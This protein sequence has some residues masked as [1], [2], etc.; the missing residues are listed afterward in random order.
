[1]MR[2]SSYGVLAVDPAR[3]CGLAMI[4][5]GGMW[6]HTLVFRHV[7]SQ[8][9]EVALLLAHLDGEMPWANADQWH[10]VA[11]QM[12][13][14]KHQQNAFV[15]A[16]V[17]GQIYQELGRMR[18]FASAQR[19]LAGTW[20]N[21][22]WRG[23]GFLQRDLAKAAAIDLVQRRYGVT[24][25]DNSAEAICIALWRQRELEREAKRL[26]LDLPR[27][28]RRKRRVAAKALPSTIRDKA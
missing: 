19:V 13:P 14:G 21:I 6:C 12:Y 24:V 17:E 11:E 25:D 3:V 1:M 16:I 28:Q 27:P 5:P 20:R 7:P 23:A 9:Q 8:P 4:W 15:D 18:E 2:M 26:Q 22:L 10:Y